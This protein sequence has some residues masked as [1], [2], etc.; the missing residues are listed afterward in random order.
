MNM[1]KVLGVDGSALVDGFS[2][3]VDDAAERGGSDWHL[4]G[5]AGIS[6]RLATHNALSSVHSNSAHSVLTQVLRHFK[7]ETVLAA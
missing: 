1:S 4:D 2:D 7:N 3:D 5:G 6:D